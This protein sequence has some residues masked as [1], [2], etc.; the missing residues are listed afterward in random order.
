M[1]GDADAISAVVDIRLGQ[2]RVP[3]ADSLGIRRGV[4]V[5]VRDRRRPGLHDHHRRRSCARGH[6]R[7]TR[8]EV[9]KGRATSS[10]SDRCTIRGTRAA[11]SMFATNESSKARTNCARQAAMPTYARTDQ[12]CMPG[13]I[14]RN[15]RLLRVASRH[16]Q[17]C[18]SRV[19]TVRGFWF[20]FAAEHRYRSCVSGH[21]RAAVRVAPCC[22][23][24]V[25]HGSTESRP[26]TNTT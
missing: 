3:S 20:E 13:G 2:R 8:L 1:A 11:R 26:K 23:C 22:Y 4:R 25:A 19:C 9:A 12:P 7:A 10:R 5:D 18:V 24:V 6:C 21:R 17:S 16:E 14:P 15:S